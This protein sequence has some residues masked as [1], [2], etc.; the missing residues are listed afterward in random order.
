MEMNSCAAVKTNPDICLTSSF[1]EGRA[2]VVTV[3]PSTT[4]VLN[5]D[6]KEPECEVC[7]IDGPAPNCSPTEMTL[8]GVE[9]H[10]L[11]FSC[12]NPQDV[13]TVKTKKIIGKSRRDL[14]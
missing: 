9:N 7:S 11:E 3:D 14:T 8:T 5:R 6:P 12:M 4:V 1:L 2:M 10:P 13:Y